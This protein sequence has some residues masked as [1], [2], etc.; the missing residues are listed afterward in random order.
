MNYDQPMIR[1]VTTNLSPM[2]LTVDPTD[3]RMF[4]GDVR[5]SIHDVQVGS[6]TVK[7]LL[8]GHVFRG[9]PSSLATTLDASKLMIKDESGLYVWKLDRQ[10]EIIYSPIW[11]KLD[12][13]ITC[14]ALAPDS[15][16][17]FYG[18]SQH[19]RSQVWE[20]EIGSGNLKP[21]FHDLSGTLQR[22][23]ISRDGLLLMAVSSSGAII[24]WKRDTS[25]HPWEEYPIDELDTSLSYAASFSPHSQMLITCDREGHS[26]EGVEL[27]GGV[28]SCT[29]SPQLMIMSVAV[30][31]WMTSKS[32]RGA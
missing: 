32:C 31:F 25:H 18:C 14:F 16:T 2:C 27:D 24:L 4:V 6:A 5:G 11:N 8:L 13:T 10:A 12:R 21:I 7:S 22:I 1:D 3:L 9:F 20:F 19:N 30:S 28:N 23:V 29:N 15:S 26:F 17:G